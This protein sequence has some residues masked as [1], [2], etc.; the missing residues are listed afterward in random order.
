M[1][2]NDCVVTTFS[3]AV[4]FI[5]LSNNYTYKRSQKIAEVCHATSISNLATDDGNPLVLGKIFHTLLFF[6]FAL[7]ILTNNWIL[8]IALLA[9]ISTLNFAYVM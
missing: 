6:I 7:I 2:N 8:M 1:H 4:L 3:L 9:I 5:I